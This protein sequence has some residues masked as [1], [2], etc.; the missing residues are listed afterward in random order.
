MNSIIN[1]VNKILDYIGMDGL[2]H[3][4]VCIVLMNIFTLFL[5]VLAS[6]II[7][8][9]IGIGKELIW[10]KLLKKGTCDIKDLWCD[11]VGIVIG[12]I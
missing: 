1:I 5:P 2:L 8:A 3:I 10:D 4:L 9:V 7:V 11:L 6:I 12:I